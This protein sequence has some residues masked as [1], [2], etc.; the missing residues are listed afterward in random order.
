MVAAT[1]KCSC[2]DQLVISGFVSK[3]YFT[4]S[5]NQNKLNKSWKI[6]NLLNLNN[7]V[8]KKKNKPNNKQQ[9]NWLKVKI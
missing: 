2:F 6:T 4:I 3:F 8:G 1:L 7:N 5:T 9:R